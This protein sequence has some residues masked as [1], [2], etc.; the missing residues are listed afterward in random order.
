MVLGDDGASLIIIKH[1]LELCAAKR[2]LDFNADSLG[3]ALYNAKNSGYR[4][5]RLDTLKVRNP[6]IYEILGVTYKEN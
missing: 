6:E 4:P 3:N 1:W 5:M 2:E